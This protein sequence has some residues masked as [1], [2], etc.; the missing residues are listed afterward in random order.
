MLIKNGLVFTENCQF[1]RSD[2]IVENGKITDILP[3]YSGKTF[4]TETI[5][6]E[7]CY[8][9]PGLVDIHSHGAVNRDLC[10]GDP[11]GIKA[12]LA[13]NGAQGVTSIL[14][15]T[16]ACPKPTLVTAIETAVP[17]INKDGYGTV[18]RGI[19]MEGPFFSIEKRGA[20]N[21]E[22]I[23]PPDYGYFNE[24][25]DLAQGHIKLLDLA[26]EIKG[27][28]GFIAEARKKCTVSLAHTSAGYDEAIAAFKAGASHV[29]HLFNGMTGFT[30]KEPGIVGAAAELA[31][32]VELISD[33]FHVHPAAVRAVFTWFGVNR[34]CLISDSMRAAGMPDGTY[35]LMGQ[36]INVND[37][38]AFL[39]KDG[40]YSIAGSVTNLAD[41]CRRAVGFG[42]TL[43]DAVQ[44]AT[45][46]PARAVGLD[47]EVGSLARGKRADILLWDRDYK[48]RT[49]ICGGKIFHHVGFNK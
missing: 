27:S 6:A 40:Y 12:I 17:Y 29:T 23:I 49:V 36:T 5:D 34:V 41:M 4:P 37:G 16:M 26:P 46:N 38:K 30:H 11:A 15:A 28:L 31:A 32:H 8:V 10:D 14:L 22:Y 9:L 44:A 1:S 42:I 7:G 2:V 21:P 13:Y 47:N 18:L 35:D 3:S 24:I 19:N 20:Q 33:G 45:I 39:S 43:E 25:Y 48:T